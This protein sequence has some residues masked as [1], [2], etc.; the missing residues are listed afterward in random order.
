M[1]AD[2]KAIR[3]AEPALADVDYFAPNDGKTLLL[4]PNEVT[5]ESIDPGDY[6]AWDCLNDFYGLESI[7]PNRATIGDSHVLLT[8]KGLYNMNL[9]GEV[10]GKLPG[11][12]SVEANS[13]GGDGPTICAQRSGSTIE[14]VVDRA[15]G[16][17]PGGCTTHD[18]H[19]FV[20]TAAGMIEAR[21]VWSPDM[22]ETPPDWFSRVCSR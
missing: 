19:R 9:V 1:V 14:Y 13:F 8:L 20:S 6:S 18:A 17:C 2:V 5:F 21:E 12:E 7:E 15:G 10:Y 4:T 3:A 11:I 16:D 22:F